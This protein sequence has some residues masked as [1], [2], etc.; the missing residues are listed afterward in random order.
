MV[1]ELQCIRQHQQKHG[2]LVRVLDAGWLR[3]CGTSRA[4]EDEEAWLFNP[5]SALAAGP[6]KSREGSDLLDN[7]EGSRVG[8]QA[9]SSCEGE[10]FS[11]TKFNRLL[12]P[13][14]TDF[15]ILVA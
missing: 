2:A 1:D 9:A 11:T 8:F 7:R 13:K 5:A 15:R 14:I 3:Q 12:A 10:H 6:R 4:H